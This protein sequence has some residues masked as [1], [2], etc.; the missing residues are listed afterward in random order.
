M[1]ME[2]GTANQHLKGHLLPLDQLS[3]P[4]LPSSN[5]PMF[6]TKVGMIRKAGVMRRAGVTTAAK[7]TAEDAMEVALEWENVTAAGTM[8]T[9]TAQAEAMKAVAGQKQ[10]RWRRT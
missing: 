2:Q 4:L 10:Q 6:D 1:K 9:N 5:Q 8:A 7:V 3:T